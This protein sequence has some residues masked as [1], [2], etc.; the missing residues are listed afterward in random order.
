MELIAARFSDDHD[1]A[2]ARAP[3]LRRIG[4]DVEFELGHSVDDRIEDHLSRFGLQDADAVIDVFVGPRAAAIDAGQK[5]TVW[6]RNARGES[7]ERDEVA[8]VKRQRSDFLRLDVE[9]DFGSASLQQC[10]TRGDFNRL[11]G[12][13][14]FK[15]HIDG[16]AIRQTQRDTGLA[17]GA[18][19]RL[20]DAENIPSSRESEDMICAPLVRS[21]VVADSS[22]LIFGC[23]FG[24]ENG[25]SGG[26]LNRA[27]ELSSARLGKAGDGQGLEKKNSNNL[28][29]VEHKCCP[30]TTV[31]G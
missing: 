23:G 29:S 4:V 18:E 16:R 21:N 13:A 8:S 30:Q 31:L 7:D 6:K 14:N 22:G 9:A 11:I 26:V 27:K 15:L 20:L 19:T 28:R 5:I 3:V 10:R 25:E 1:S 24:L 17:V 2:A 12:Q